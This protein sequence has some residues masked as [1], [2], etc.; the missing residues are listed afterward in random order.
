MKRI[1][2]FEKV[3]MERFI[4]DWLATFLSE[5]EKKFG[6]IDHDDLMDSLSKKAQTIYN[7]LKLP[8]R[9]TMGSA[10]YDFYSPLSF[11]LRPGETIKIPTGIRV[12]IKMVGC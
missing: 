12:K 5:E 6:D 4:K 3:S 7:N 1:A 10:G 2:Q 9:A 8:R 11:T